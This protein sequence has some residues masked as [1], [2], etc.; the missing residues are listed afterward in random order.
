T[1][2]A[3]SGTGEVLPQ[4]RPRWEG[5]DLYWATVEGSESYLCRQSGG[6]VSCQALGSAWVDSFDVE[7][8]RAV[9]SVWDSSAGWVVRTV[10][11]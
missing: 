8:N 11:F 5:E 7:G 10:D 6:G 1:A 9:A 3:I 2:T 4:L